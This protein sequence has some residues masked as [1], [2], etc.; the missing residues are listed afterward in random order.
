MAILSKCLAHLAA[1][2]RQTEDEDYLIDFT[3]QGLVLRTSAILCNLS[4]NSERAETAGTLGP[5]YGNS[6][7]SDT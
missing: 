6:E 3:K 4:T 2:K 7:L 1:K 5:L